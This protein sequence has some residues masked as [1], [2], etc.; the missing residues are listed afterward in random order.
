MKE[1]ST[2]FSKACYCLI[3]TL[4]LL[5]GLTFAQLASIPVTAGSF[6]VDIVAEGTGS[7]PSA[8]T[9][10]TL[11]A[12]TN[13]IF[14]T[15]AFQGANLLFI[16][17]G[18]LPNNGTITNGSDTWQMQPFT[19]NNC[20]YFAPQAAASTRSMTL[21]TASKFSQIALMA[22]AGN[23]TCSVTIFLHF[24][25]GTLPNYGTFTV[26]DWFGGT[27][28]IT[29]G[30]GRITRTASTLTTASSGLPN[31]PRLY[32][33]TL[34]LTGT[35][36]LKTMDRIDV[37]D[38]NTGNTTSVGFF[39][40]SATF[41]VLPLG[42]APLQA[43]YSSTEK[44]VDLQWST[45]NN[46]PDNSFEVQRSSDGSSFV[47]IGTLHPA[48]SNNEQT[49]SYTDQ[50]SNNSSQWF[51]RV[52]ETSSSS[53]EFT[54]TNV[55]SVNTGASG[56]VRAIQNGRT[57]HLSGD[58]SAAGYAFALYDMNG[59]KL[60]SGLTAATDGYTIPIGRLLSGVYVLRIQGNGGT[61]SFKFFK[62]KE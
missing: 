14:Y 41:T 48:S 18:G 62:P 8:V 37:Q 38:N 39:A 43:H 40:L 46:T 4:C 32:Q 49:L 60:F 12:G 9:T 17:G 55:I 13:N 42:M 31:D 2:N 58:L 16:S 35:D 52:K 6:N 21:T 23:G 5:P 33:I 26:N 53:G 24:T 22:T 11:D 61:Q 10:G 47:T 56:S 3:I 54:Y 50:P 25:D 59:K 1:K 36:Q 19:A 7:N 51:Y 15:K 28:Y 29:N 57:M 30:L 27:P 45:F 34:N 44:S 20:M